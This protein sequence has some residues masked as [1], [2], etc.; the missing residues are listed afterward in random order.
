MRH[1]S[2]NHQLGR[3]SR[4]RTL[5]THSVEHRTTVRG[6]RAVARRALFFEAEAAEHESAIE[7]LVMTICRSLLEVPGVGG[8]TAAQ[9][10]V[11]WSHPGR[12]RNEAAF[13]SL[14]GV[15]PIPASSGTTVRHRLNRSASSTAPSTPWRCPGF[16]ITPRRKPMTL[17]ELGKARHHARSS[18]AS[19]V[20]LPARSTV[21]WKLTQWGYTSFLTPLD[22]TMN[23][24]MAGRGLAG[25]GVGRSTVVVTHNM[26]SS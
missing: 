1:G 16:N 8:V 24:E 4:L 21:I 13:A 3:G 7:E 22:S 11:S 5:P 23:I 26:A 12:V 9:F 10:I 15:A 6:I 17:A 14:A 25:R 19:N 18:V 20:P 2:T